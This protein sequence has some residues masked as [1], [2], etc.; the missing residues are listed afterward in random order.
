MIVH[1]NEYMFLDGSAVKFIAYREDKNY[2]FEARVPDSYWNSD[3][4]TGLLHKEA[5]EWAVETALIHFGLNQKD[6]FTPP[7]PWEERLCV[8]LIPLTNVP[9]YVKDNPA[10]YW[11]DFEWE[12]WTEIN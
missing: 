5:Q 4:E 9:D 8:V 3:V 1:E 2:F 7:N 6:Y 12:T 10:N 11:Y